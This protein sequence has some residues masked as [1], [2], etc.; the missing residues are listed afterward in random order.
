MVEFVEI[1]S[2]DDILN[3]FLGFES[4]FPKICTNEERM[5][6]YAL[7]LMKNA[8]VTVALTDGC[9]SGIASYYA[10]DKETCEG[11]ISMFGVKSG[12]R[13]KH[14]GQKLM[15]H[16]ISIMKMRGME[17]VKLEVK[18]TNTVAMAFYKAVGFEVYGPSRASYMYMQKVI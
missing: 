8:V 4:C 11:Y 3:A 14:I 1:E 10:N 5:K 12:F 13:G 17:T 16:C 15:E 18:E 6:S 9:I 7:K 2:Y